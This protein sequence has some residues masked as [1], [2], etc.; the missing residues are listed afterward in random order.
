M[1]TV[2]KI[3]SGDDVL[4][5]TPPEEGVIQMYISEVQDEQSWRGIALDKND[6]TNLI[7]YLQKYLGELE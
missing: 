2:L 3:I 7:E 4:E 5:V 1:A 6:T